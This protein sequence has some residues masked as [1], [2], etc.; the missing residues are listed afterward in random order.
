MNSR[1]IARAKE[2]FRREIAN[3]IFSMKDPRLHKKLITVSNIEIS[4]DFLF[5][6]VYMTSVDSMKH[7]KIICKILNHASNYIQ[8]NLAKNLKTRFVPKILF[9]PNNSEEYAFKINNILSKNNKSTLFE[10]SE[11]LKKNNNFA[12]F[13][14]VIPYGDAILIIQIILNLNQKILYV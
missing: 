14:Q 12:I 7:S 6:K 2:S 1:R 11:F 3:I 4:N 5:C 8:I 10:I 9:I 13:I